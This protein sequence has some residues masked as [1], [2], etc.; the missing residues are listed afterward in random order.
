M[1]E[2]QHQKLQQ[3]HDNFLPKPAMDAL[4]E[5]PTIH[6]RVRGEN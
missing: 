5:S 2:T 3:H 1:L 4:V 6:A